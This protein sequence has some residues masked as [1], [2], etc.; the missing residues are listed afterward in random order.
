MAHLIA[1]D[2]PPYRLLPST[3]RLL[4]GDEPV[5]LGGRAFDLLVALIERRDRVVGKGELMDLVWP[6]LVVEENNLQV[7]ITVLRK[8]L[9]HP[10]IA[11]IPG[12]G[13]QFTTPVA[14]QG[15]DESSARVTAFG[16][17]RLESAQRSALP[18]NTPI[19]FG[20]DEDLR[21][22]CDLVHLHGLVTVVGMAGIGKTRL[23][24][25]VA[26]ASAERTQGDAWWV[27][28]APLQDAS[29]VPGAVAMALGLNVGAGT[30]TATAVLNALRER[31]GLLV[32]DN[33]EHLLEG[34]SAFVTRLH[35]AV[36]RARLLVTSQEA[37][38]IEDEHVF[39]P[40]PLSLPEA[41]DPERMGRSGAVSLFMARA[42]ESDRHFELRED[43]RAAIAEI[44]RRLD[45]IPLAIE[46]AAARVCLLG[47]EGLRERL[48][49]RFHLLTAGRRAAL[50]RHQTLRG[51]L[52]WSYNLLSRDEQAVLCRLAVF[53]GGFT[54]EAAQQLADDAGIDCWDVLEHLGALVDKSLVVAEGDPLPRYRLL[55]TTRL[56]ALERLI[57]SGET[58]AVRRRHRDY[59]LALAERSHGN[60]LVGNTRRCI[61][62]VDRE[63][64]NLLQALA[65]ATGADDAMPGLRLAAALHHYW[66]LRAMPSLGLRVTRAA[67]ERTGAQGRSLERCRALVTAGWMSTLS[68]DDT[69]AVPYMQEALSLA[70]ELR[71]DAVLCFALVKFAH[72][73]HHRNEGEEAV[74]LLSEALDVGHTLG[75]SVELSDALSLR[76]HAY[77]RHGER[78]SA[79]SLFNEALALRERLDLPSGILSV[80]LNLAFMAIEEGSTEESRRHLLD[81]LALIARTESVS[82]A[83]HLTGHT[84]Q[85]AADVGNHKASVLLEAACDGLLD[86]FGMRNELEP[87]EVT[88]LERARSAL[89]TTTRQELEVTGRSLSYELALRAVAA[90]LHGR[91]ERAS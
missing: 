66:H 31:T 71:D 37:L 32:L 33:A 88:R 45:G 28:L 4:R 3:R 44:C 30:D 34:L 84:A 69:G 35:Q 49:Q 91:L 26:A 67:L 85:W 53:V 20:R 65:W 46:L 64:E 13:Y 72:L 75:D 40:E 81:A 36:P 61:A 47:V 83:I 55:E 43:N 89:D 56:F 48:D 14:E 12:R 17:V 50:R 16:G 23:A 1:Y 41:D 79:R 27:E 54:L 74:R 76:A 77:L 19:L 15:R 25:A 7:Q 18:P 11:T 57:E 86:R 38:N 6:A 5:K 52:E 2:F 70:R 58:D 73:R 82:G 24:Q 60:L 78:E 22:L 51:A 10:A 29:L 39:R 68:G 9:G 90:C 80:R 21:T 59:F 42:K 87:S 63:R 8:L 62:E